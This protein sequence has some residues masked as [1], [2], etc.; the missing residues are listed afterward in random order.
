MACSLLCSKTH[1]SMF[2][3]GE[4]KLTKV[5]V[6]LVTLGT[7][8]NED[9]RQSTTGLGRYDVTRSCCACSLVITCAQCSRRV[10]VHN[11]TWDLLT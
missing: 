3:K 10:P 6:P 7:L 9:G 4:I 5:P 11:F 2:V 1:D 8:S